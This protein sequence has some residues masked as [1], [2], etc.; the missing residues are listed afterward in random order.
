MS[1]TVESVR[2]PR[3]VVTARAAEEIISVVSPASSAGTDIIMYARAVANSSISFADR[4]VLLL[5]AKGYRHIIMK[6]ASQQLRQDVQRVVGLTED[7]SLL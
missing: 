7:M 2:L 6:G 3:V 1:E 4:L 5:K